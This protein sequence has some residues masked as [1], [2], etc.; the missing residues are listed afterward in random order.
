MRLEVYVD[1]SSE[2]YGVVLLGDSKIVVMFSCASSKPN[3]HSTT[4]EMEGFMKTLRAFR[5][6]LLGQPF[7]VFSDNWSVLRVPQGTSK[8]L[9]RMEEIMGWHPEIQFVERKASGIAN[10]LS[11]FPLYKLP[12]HV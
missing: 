5:S 3:E 1:A 6:H 2:G 11:R 12:I 10:W 9:R 8:S 4:S 7:V